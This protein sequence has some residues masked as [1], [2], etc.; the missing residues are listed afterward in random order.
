MSINP[1][2]EPADEHFTPDTSKR[3]AAITF[4]SR[5]DGSITN[6]EGRDFEQN[7]WT[8]RV[9]NHDPK[10]KG[11]GACVT[12]AYVRFSDE[13]LFDEVRARELMENIDWGMRAA[14]G[15]LEDHE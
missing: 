15:V 4:P 10:P 13:E 8:Y 5:L 9:T 2:L 11:G 14:N 3:P 7:W 1:F 12:G 6:V